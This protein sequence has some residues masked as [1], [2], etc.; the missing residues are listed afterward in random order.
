MYISRVVI[1][2]F[3]L[4]GSSPIE[5]IHRR[6]RSMCGDGATDVRRWVCCFKSGD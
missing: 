3:T 4:E 2:L 1:E 5:M 6:L